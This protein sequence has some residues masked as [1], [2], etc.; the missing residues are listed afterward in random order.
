MTIKKIHIKPYIS[1]RQSLDE[2]ELNMRGGE[3]RKEELKRR[4]CNGA[5]AILEMKLTEIETAVAKKNKEIYRH[6][7][8]YLNL[9]MSLK[10]YLPNAEIRNLDLRYENLM[11]KY[12][13]SANEK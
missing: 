6:T 1:S 5:S 9:F 4:A 12:R 11:L 13:S 3:S 2:L 8:P 10:K 7:I